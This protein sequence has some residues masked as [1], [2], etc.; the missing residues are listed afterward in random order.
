METAIKIGTE[1][2]KE[3][4]KNLGDLIDKV[5]SSAAKNRMEQHTI[6]EALRIVAA[7]LSV[8]GTTINGCH[9]EGEKTINT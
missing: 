7:S 8:S 5:F 1:V 4:T 6:I 2:S 9:I 3:S